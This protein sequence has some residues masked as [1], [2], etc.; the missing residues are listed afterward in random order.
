MEGKRVRKPFKAYK[1]FNKDL[2]CR[3]FQYEVGGVY[4]HQGEL[5]W[6]K[7]GFHASRKC[8]DVFNFY[9]FD[10]EQTRV[11]EVLIRG[12]MIEESEDKLVC[13]RIEVIRELSW[14]E[15]LR[16][17]NTGNSNTGN[18]NTGHRNTGH[19]NTGDWNTGNWNTGNWNSCNNETGFLNTKESDTIRVFNKPCKRE[20]WGKAKKPNF[21][22]FEVI[23]EV[24]NEKGEKELKAVEYK[25][26]WK[27]S[28]DNTTEQDRRL[29]EKLPNFSWKVLS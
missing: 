15:V 5:I 29:V 6:C 10:P 11:C 28:W 12:Q 17:V 22:Y 7:S 24:E 3:G 20:E 27:R 23:E 14:N 13:S 21:F 4:Q 19:R 16:E 9:L 8:A 2:T 25:E 26:A 1:A 18:S